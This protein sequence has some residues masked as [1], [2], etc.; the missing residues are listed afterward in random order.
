M[1]PGLIV[2]LHK[3]YWFDFYF[4]DIIVVCA[5]SIRVHPLDVEGGGGGGGGRGPGS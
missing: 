1:E 3:F 2:D 4:S 5:I